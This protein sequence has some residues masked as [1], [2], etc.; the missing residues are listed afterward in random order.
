M[1]IMRFVIYWN[2]TE[3]V[4]WDLELERRVPNNNIG[5]YLL[6][7][8]ELDSNYKQYRYNRSF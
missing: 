6:S 5:D 3:T 8:G 2:M 4:I 1:I 7:I